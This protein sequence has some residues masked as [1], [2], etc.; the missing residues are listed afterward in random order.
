VLAEFDAAPEIRQRAREALGKARRSG[1][2]LHLD[3]MAFSAAPSLP[4]DIAVMEKTQ[5]AA[6]APCSIGWADI[7]SWDEIWRLSPKDGAGNVVVGPVAAIDVANAL[8]RSEGVK[9][10][11]AGVNDLIVVATPEAVI[12]L[13]RERAQE[14]KQLRDLADE[15]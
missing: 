6:V 4:F 10:C 9:L 8:L 15:L 5:R 1:A 11:V 7:G 14:V 3:A 12:I 13:P 2:E